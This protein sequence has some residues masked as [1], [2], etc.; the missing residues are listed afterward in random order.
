MI[1]KADNLKNES[2]QRSRALLEEIED[3][4]EKMVPLY[5]KKNSLSVK[6]LYKTE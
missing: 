6:E 1:K 2:P 3:L 4:R 5:S